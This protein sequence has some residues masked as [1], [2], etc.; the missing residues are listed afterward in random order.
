MRFRMV[1]S[2]GVAF[3]VSV[4]QAQDVDPNEWVIESYQFPSQE[5]VFGYT[6]PDRGFLKAPQLPNADADEEVVQ[7]FIRQ[8]NSIVSHYFEIQG[9]TYPVGALFVF[10]P[11]STTLS[12]R[13]PQRAQ[14]TVLFA[15]ESAQDHAPKYVP[16][17]VT[18]FETSA[19]KMREVIVDARQSPEHRQLLDELVEEAEGG[20][21]NV[22]IISTI[23][24]EA[25][26]GQRAKTHQVENVGYPFDLAIIG[27]ENVEF[28]DDVLP[29]ETRLEIDPVIGA[30]GLQID[31]NFTLNFHYAPAA[32]RVEPVTMRGG[33]ALSASLTDTHDV[34]ITNS[35][36]LLSG[37]AKLLGTWKPEHGPNHNADILQ[38]AFLEA[39]I[40]AVLPLMND[41]VPQLLT[42]HGEAVLEIP[43]GPP[44]FEELEGDLPQGM[45]VRRFRV[46][47]NAITNAYSNRG[48]D[49][50]SDPFASFGPAE[51]R[52][53]VAATAKDLL[54]AS[55]VPFPE[56]AS[57]NYMTATGELV[58]R[59]TPENIELVEAFLDTSEDLPRSVGVTTHIVQGPSVLMRRLARE[60][61]RLPDHAAAW[62]EF[63]AAAGQGRASIL[64]STWMEGRSGQRAKVESGLMHQH[65]SEA[66][67]PAISGEGDAGAAETNASVSTSLE[68]DRV[69][70]TI[71][72]DPVMGADMKMIDLNISVNYDYAPAATAG[73]P[74]VEADG[75]IVLD[76]PTTTFHEAS[77]ITSL[78]L[79]SGM[80]RMIGVWEPRGTEE[81][82]EADVLQAV[83]VRVDVLRYD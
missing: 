4:A 36:T 60:S 38:A 7:D 47:P 9:V 70:T 80:T 82:D 23:R 21:D 25:K 52:F 81:F 56:G 15:A 11:E 64:R 55:G 44:Q 39:D 17:D 3:L 79:Q 58:I 5:L 53:S 63:E 68:S 12:A 75:A 19:A 83:F 66:V 31:V 28:A 32:K 61:R 62:A 65:I 54:V 69:G 41:R 46:P 72:T 71:E 48:D 30:D 13:L 22:R 34:V 59:N 33:E 18:I 16:F 37:G 43:D 2:L 35:M 50:A 14:S 1:V 57:A 51:P 78:T 27:D 29:V 73:E 67:V 49:G 74:E 26:S 45:I 6:S 20:D 76:G 24:T 77:V 40:V 8:S 42:N 10:D